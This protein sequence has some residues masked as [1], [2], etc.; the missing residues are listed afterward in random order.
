[1]SDEFPEGHLRNPKPEEGIQFTNFVRKP[2]IVQ[3]IEITSENIYDISEFVGTIRKK[4][5]GTPYIQ[6][7]RR[8]VPNMLYVYPGFWMT[9][10][11]DNIRCYSK[12]AF[13]EQFVKSSEDIEKWVKFLNKDSK[14]QGFDEEETKVG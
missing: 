1:M 3:A 2:F 14:N 9:R 10:I 6:V 4:G 5:N 7:D 11:G 13:M 12:R 8:L